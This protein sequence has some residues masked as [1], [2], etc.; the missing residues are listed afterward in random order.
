MDTKIQNWFKVQ[1]LLTRS[2]LTLRKLFKDRWL[3]FTGQ[4]WLDTPADGQAYITGIS[5]KISRNCRNIQQIVLQTGDTN[6][7]DFTLLLNILRETKV[8]RQLNKVDK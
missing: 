7:W 1:L 6:Q 8:T 5:R 4:Q 3:L 2:C